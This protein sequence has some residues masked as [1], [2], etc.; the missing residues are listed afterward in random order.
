MIPFHLSFVSLLLL[1]CRL[2]LFSLNRPL[3]LV[4]PVCGI[5]FTL[6]FPRYLT[7][8]LWRE[9]VRREGGDHFTSFLKIVADYQKKED[10]D[11]ELPEVRLVSLFSFLG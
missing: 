8:Y 5:F 10:D 11:E 4:S 7:E 3:N 6:L 1:F 2:L 9:K